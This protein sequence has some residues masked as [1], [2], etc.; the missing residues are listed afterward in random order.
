MAVTVTNLSDSFEDWRVN[1]NLSHSQQGDLTILT[2]TDKTSI[3]AA[4]NE[5]AASGLSDNSVDLDQMA[6]G[7][8]N[9]I[10]SYDSGTVPI[11]RTPAQV[12]AFLKVDATTSSKGIVEKST[13]GENVTGT[14]A[15]KY[16]SVAGVKEMIDTHA[17]GGGQFKGDNG[18]VGSA[19]G[20]IFRIN[21]AILTVD[22]TIASGENASAT[23]PLTID[24]GIT[25]T[26]EGNL[27]I[28]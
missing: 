26:V 13:S 16:P 28:I 24:T 4:L 7:T 8:E 25:L 3:V 22:E 27:T 11:R 21:N 2:T 17:Q 1:L 18:T 23:G 5:V 14:A 12:W 20:D 9:Y 10:L 15:E 6:H 19:P